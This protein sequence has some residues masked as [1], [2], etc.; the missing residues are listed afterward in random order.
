MTSAAE[1][2][3]P[4]VDRS[5]ANALE[6]GFPRKRALFLDRDG[7]INHD[8][9]YVHTPEQ[10]EWLPGIFDLVRLAHTAGYLPIVVTNQAGIGRGYYSEHDFLSYT[11]WV[12]GQFRRQRAPLLATYYC[13]HHPTAGVGVLKV[14]CECRKPKPGMLLAA[15]ERFEVDASR[16]V[17]V[18]DKYSDLEAGRS[19]GLGLCLLLASG[20]LDGVMAR[21]HDHNLLSTAGS[22]QGRNVWT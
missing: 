20:N 17:L 13:P 9:G 8:G 1:V 19:A 14:E 6:S 3:Q 15:I 2:R 11:D 21:L 4:Y 16:S 5:V 10:T 12:H 18:G 22:R 7:V